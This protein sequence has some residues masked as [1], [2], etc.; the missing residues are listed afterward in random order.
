MNASDRSLVTILWNC[1]RD[2]LVVVGIALSVLQLVEVRQAIE[3]S[4]RTVQL[5]GAG[6]VLGPYFDGSSTAAPVAFAYAEVTS[7]VR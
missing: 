5:A 7:R 1:G 6:L 2:L 4:S 3:V